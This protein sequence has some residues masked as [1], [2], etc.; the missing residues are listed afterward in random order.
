MFTDWRLMNGILNQPVQKMG[1]RCEADAFEPIVIIL[2]FLLSFSVVFTQ[3]LSVDSVQ[4][5]KNSEKFG[6]NR[7]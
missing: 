6:A 4:F 7:C 5:L 2:K 1:R 3:Y